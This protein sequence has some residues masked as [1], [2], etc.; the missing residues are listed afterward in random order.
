VNT[1]YLLLI[2]TIFMLVAY[3]TSCAAYSGSG[4]DYASLIDNLRKA[5]AVV[6]PGG[7]VAPDLLS[8]KRMV[9]SVND[10]NVAVW[11]YDDAAAADAE[12]ALISLDGFSV[13]YEN[14]AK[15]VEWIAP[16]HFY[17]AGNLIV[18][19]VGESEA[20]TAVLESV[21]GTQFAGQ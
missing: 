15:L 18:L 13:H 7:E 19:Y 16:P 6:E 11:E 21:L 5:G 14:T 9:I 2:I 8:A 20:V 4:G 1:R 3:N 12:A 10:S 17:K